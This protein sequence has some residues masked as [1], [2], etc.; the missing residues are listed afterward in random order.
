MNTTNNVTNPIKGRATSIPLLIAFGVLGVAAYFAGP[1][2]MAYV[3][4]F[5]EEAKSRAIYE[6]ARKQN[7]SGSV[8]VASTEMAPV[9]GPS[10]GPRGAMPEPEELFKRRDENGNG[11]LEG[12]EISERMQSRIAE[13]DKDG[14]GA[15]SK[16]EFMA[17]RRPG[18]NATSPSA[19]SVDAVPNA[20]KPE[21]TVTSV[22][23]EPAKE[24]PK[25]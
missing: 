14:D 9:G 10:G 5:Q 22:T 13:L 23:E 11:K 6:S 1:T 15:I 18:G 7:M 2:A 16:E 21:T 4:L 25:E 3:F 20:G 19:P 17:Q 8:E 24:A 12:S